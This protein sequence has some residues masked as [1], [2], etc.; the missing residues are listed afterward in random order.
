MPFHLISL[1]IPLVEVA[2]NGNTLGFRR[3]AYKAHRN[4]SILRR[5]TMSWFPDISL[6]SLH[7]EFVSCDQ[8]RFLTLPTVSAAKSP[9]GLSS[10][11]H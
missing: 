1:R 9:R 11:G 10:G 3:R 8:F 7:I 2:D 6:S 5:I 4:Q